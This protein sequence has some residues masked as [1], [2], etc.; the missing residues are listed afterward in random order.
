[1][2][3]EWV[4]GGY[5]SVTNGSNLVTGYET[6]WEI[7]GII[8]GDIFGGPDGKIYEITSAF[9]KGLTGPGNVS[10]ER[11]TIRTISGVDAYRG[12]TGTSEQHC[13]VRNWSNTTNTVLAARLAKVLKTGIL[14]SNPV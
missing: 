9:K 10:N 3:G 13:I 6:T 5:V 2:Q 8:V 14:N 4:R 12:P 1:M 7:N 11:I